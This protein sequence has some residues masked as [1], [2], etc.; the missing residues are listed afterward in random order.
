MANELKPGVYVQCDYCGEMVRFRK[1][2]TCSEEALLKK[3]GIHLLKARN[4]N[5]EDGDRWK[6]YNHA[7]DTVC[8]ISDMPKEG[9]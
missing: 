4:L 8:H 1:E 2:H 9:E 7:L 6:Y 5:K 3:I